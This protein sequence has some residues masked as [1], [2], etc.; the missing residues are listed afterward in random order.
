[1]LFTIQTYLEDYLNRRGLAD[2][3]GYAVRFA[4]QYFHYRRAMD[5][6]TFLRK[7]GR[8]RT[9]IF[10]NNGIKD[11]AGF[12]RSLVERLDGRFKKK[13]DEHNPTF[14]GGVEIER[15]RIQCLPRRTI[16]TLLL[17][18]KQAVEARAID[19]FWKSRTKGNLRQNPEKIAQTL[20]AMFATGVLKDQGILLREISSGIG[21]VD[22]GVIFS[23]TL[24]LVEIKVLTQKF[25]GPEQ[26]E[27]Y[28][29]NEGRSEG[30]LLV[31][32]TLKPGNKLDLP[33]VIPTLSGMIKVYSVD[34]NPAPP[35]R[36]K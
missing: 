20:F 21:F 23:S 7:V 9:V 6:A 10:V 15:K 27:Q 2:P 30:S 35:S 1:M 22:I 16:R 28:M 33:K 8:I 3:D 29:K 14:P 32:D 25:Q 5:T 24:H 26:L 17:E 34:V 18:F 36:L 13:L 12:E 31:I 11:R 19:G 4:N